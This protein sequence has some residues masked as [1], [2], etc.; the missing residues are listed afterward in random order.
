[1]ASKK[2]YTSLAE[3]LKKNRENAPK[4]YGVEHDIS[5]YETRLDTAG[6][7]VDEATDKRNFIEKALNLKEDQNFIFDFFEILGRPQQALFG[8]IDAA[9]KGEDVGKGALEGLKGNKETSGG[10][11]LRNAGID[12]KGING[13]EEGGLNPLSW[14]IDDVLGFGLDILADPIDLALIA[15]VPATGGLSTPAVAAKFAGDA[16]DVAKVAKTADKVIDTAKVVDKAVDT[17]K[18]IDKTRDVVKAADTASDVAKTRYALRPFQKGAKSISDLTFE[19]I[20]K[21]AKKLIKAGDNT[22]ESVL[23]VL[24]NKTIK[25]IEDTA[26]KLNIDEIQA[27]KRLNLSADKLDAYKAL[28]TM[29]QKALDSSKSLGGFLGRSRQIENISD[30]E[31]KGAHLYSKE[32]E[33]TARNIAKSMAKDAGEEQKIYEEI[34]HK[35][36]T[37]VE[38]NYDWTIKGDEIV[39]SLQPGKK[40]D[41][42]SKENAELLTK[43]LKDYGINAKFNDRYVTISNK[44]TKELSASKSA[45]NLKKLQESK[46][47]RKNFSNL[48][49]GQRLSVDDLRDIEEARAFINSSPELQDLYRRSEDFIP[50]VAS[51]A[52][53][54][55]GLDSSNITKEG[56]IPHVLSDDYRNITKGGKG[57]NPSKTYNTRKWQMT[58]NEANRLKASLNE[59]QLAKNASKRKRIESGI[60]KTNDKG[61]IIL[62]KA[63]NAIREDSAYA[64]KVERQ[65]RKVESLKKTQES[66]QELIN[67]KN[68]KE[69]NLEK[70]TPKDQKRFKVIQN[71]EGLQE[72][73]NS[74]K[75]MDVSNVKVEKPIVAVNDAFNNV[76]K[77]H[78]DLN[79]ALLKNADDDTVKTL[80]KA[81]KEAN[82]EL[83]T[84][85]K[86]LEKYA[87]KTPRDTLNKVTKAFENGKDVGE[88][89]QKARTKLALGVENTNNIY[90][91]AADISTGLTKKIELEEEELSK[92]LR[93]GANDIVYEDGV[94]Q[95]EALAKADSVL[96]SKEGKEFFKTNFFTNIDTY[97]N[98]SAEFNKS[99]Q[100]WNEAITTGIFRNT[101]YVKTFDDLEKGKI[102]YGFSKISGTEAKTLLSRYEGILPKGSSDFKETLRMLGDNKELYMDTDLVNMLKLSK[103]TSDNKLEP[104]LK[105]WDGI[106]RTF[107]KF[108]TLTL[109]FH[110]RNIMGNTTNM[111]LSGMPVSAMPTYYKK[112]ADLWNRADDLTAKFFKGTLSDAEKADWA[113]LEQFYKGGFSNESYS[114]LMGLDEIKEAKKGVINK[115]SQK[116]IDM[117]EFVDGHN[118]LALLMYANDNPHYL[119]RLGKSDAIEAVKYVLFDPSNMSDVEKTAMK[120]I[121]PFYTFTKQNLMFQAEN[122]M[123]NTPKY[124]RLFKTLNKSYDAIGEDAYNSYQK[125]SMQIPLPFTADDGSQLF[126]KANL[127]LSD[128]GEWISNPVQRV[129]S[130][131][132][133]IIKAPVE[134]VTGIDTFTGEQSYK[135]KGEQLLTSLGLQNPTVNMKKKA[136]AIIAKYNG[137]MT[138]QEMFA[139]LFRSLVQNVKSENVRQNRLYDELEE[140]QALVKSLKDEGQSVPTMT[141]INKTKGY[142]LDA[143]KRKRANS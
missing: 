11:L 89:L 13:A 102:P 56:Y 107:K 63:G 45:S 105:M 127:P 4:N 58:S 37:L 85:V 103:D 15:S 50:N 93:K 35:I 21:G 134:Y 52:D 33:D 7:D 91:S 41:M 111:A 108:S 83:K 81:V 109:G 47:A 130:S 70:L 27:A 16:A 30:I 138:N 139:E 1:M 142:R 23:K 131:T 100:I 78:K 121:M 99:A 125:E 14:G 9:Q 141:E 137:D 140:Y 98:R 110:A 80:E 94:L 55:T 43:N 135:S 143:L 62:D 53:T 112:S 129:V 96:H 5:N 87:D 84:K 17:A 12:S 34:A 69:I 79:K 95:L 117:N 2:K 77:A 72:T 42:F 36:N 60:Y 19:G 66:A 124:K 38:S 82:K 51:G 22:V 126:L 114:K 67:Y 25:K 118:R 59:K 75:S 44:G 24:D 119:K 92:L 136:D 61:E 54:L 113:I 18:V 132:T 73:V 115:I 3:T 104:L 133:P 64:K 31:R 90:Q 65:Q 101:D 106:N 76:K 128:L 26:K 20:G 8:A 49:F 10:Q 57:P 88:K 48:E 123:K 122:I 6:V 68:T 29:G 120:R 86:V 46:K 28:K 71:Q 40:I 97:I 39:G 74:L 116:S 32:L